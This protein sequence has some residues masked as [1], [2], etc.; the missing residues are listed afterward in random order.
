MAL[1]GENGSGKTTLINLLLRLVEPTTGKI[2][3]DGVDIK[4]YDINEYRR[5][6]STV[7]QSVHLFPEP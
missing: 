5:L 7:M 2:L 3:I 6:I 4:L 1:V